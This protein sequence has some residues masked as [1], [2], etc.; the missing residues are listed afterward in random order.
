VKKGKK[1]VKVAKARNKRTGA[2][3]KAEPTTEKKVPTGTVP[4]SVRFQASL[5]TAEGKFNKVI[6][7]RW[8]Q[9]IVATRTRSARGLGQQARKRSADA[10][11]VKRLGIVRGAIIHR[12]HPQNMVPTRLSAQPIRSRMAHWQ[13]ASPLRIF[14]KY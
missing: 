3:V 1:R 5:R 14:S 11:S 8:S 2:K 9:W 13:K 4:N 12:W 6:F 10:M 7:N